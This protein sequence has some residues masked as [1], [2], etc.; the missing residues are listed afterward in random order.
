MASIIECDIIESEDGEAI[1][2]GATK[3]VAITWT[4]GVA[5][6]VQQ[7]SLF[8]IGELVYISG[9]GANGGLAGGWFAGPAVGGAAVI[10]SSALPQLYWPAT[11]RH[12]SIEV[13]N[14]N[15]TFQAGDLYIKAA[16]GT[17]V[18]GSTGNPTSAAFAAAAC[19]FNLKGAYLL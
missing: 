8:Q 10:T 9:A 12:I 4:Q 17:M 16:D 14:N 18:I 7:V 19:S 3:T 1:Q 13:N 6:A 5:T 2:M 15:G 11:D